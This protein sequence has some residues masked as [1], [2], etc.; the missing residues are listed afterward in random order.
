[1][2][3]VYTTSNIM[4]INIMRVLKKLWY[5]KYGGCYGVY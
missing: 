1:M 3:G 4:L 2:N 5:N